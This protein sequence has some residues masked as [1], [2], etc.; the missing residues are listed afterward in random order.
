[1]TPAPNK[2][3]QLNERGALYIIF[4]SSKLI[5]PLSLL[6]APE[7]LKNGGKNRISFLFMH[8]LLSG[9]HHQRRVFHR[10]KKKVSVFDEE[11]PFEKGKYIDRAA[12][13][14]KLERQEAEYAEAGIQEKYFLIS[15]FF[16]FFSHQMF[17]IL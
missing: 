16:F 10:K 5:F 15:F 7:S 11:M 2:P 17:K 3:L 14:R 8:F 6:S 4:C 12:K 9:I 13:R 1:M